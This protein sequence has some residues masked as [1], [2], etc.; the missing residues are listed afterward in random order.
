MLLILFDMSEILAL[1]Q[2]F[3]KKDN[4]P[5]RR[6]LSCIDRS[7]LSRP[8]IDVPVP[9]GL[10]YEDVSDCIQHKSA[11]MNLIGT[12][13]EIVCAIAPPWACR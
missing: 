12:T 9:A 8:A 13:R 7:A 2:A 6:A 10:E 11:R 5:S 3:Y 1:P 4:L